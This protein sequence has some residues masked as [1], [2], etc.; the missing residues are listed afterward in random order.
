MAGV[1]G[2]APETVAGQGVVWGEIGTAAT[3]RGGGEMLQAEAG[4]E[5]KVIIRKDELL[6][7]G[8]SREPSRRSSLLQAKKMRKER[9]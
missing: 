1:D 2:E 3:R 6:S 8:H 9:R 4:S 5:A 7:R